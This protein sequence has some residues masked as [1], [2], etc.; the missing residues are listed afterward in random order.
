[1]FV[2]HMVV[3]NQCEL[4]IAVN[5]WCMCEVH[6]LSGSLWLLFVA[7]T[8]VVAGGIVAGVVRAAAAAAVT[9]AQQINSGNQF[10]LALI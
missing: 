9:A 5:F 3:L 4:A 8:G 7:G 1:M 6:C 2:G 10:S